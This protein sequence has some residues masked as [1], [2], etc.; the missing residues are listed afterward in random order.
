MLTKQQMLNALDGLIDEAARLHA[1]FLTDLAS[2]SPDFAVWLKA[3]ESTVEAIFGTN[4]QALGS[5]KA[6]Y[7][8]PPPGEQYTNELEERKAKM[9]WFDSGLRYAHATLVGYRYSV[10]RLTVEAPARPTPYIFIAHGGPT[11]THVHLVR[12]FLAA[13]GLSGVVV[14]DLPNLNL[15]ANEKV[16]FYMSLCAGGI[17][18]ATLEDE[19]T[20]REG[21][22]RPNVENEIG[23][24]QTAP[25][26]GARITCLK[27]DGVQFASNYA[28]KIW[29]PFVKDRVQDVFVD[30]AKELRAF[31]FL[32]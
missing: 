8:L 28:E 32:G 26:I 24:M 23:M 1:V 30:I 12:D 6:I 15:S 5:F 25:N 10:D 7:F 21:R 9:T 19:T 27:E 3:A 2:W 20:A 11:L 22:T 4:S 31:G 17:A 18:L 16:R 14:R 13:L 29:I